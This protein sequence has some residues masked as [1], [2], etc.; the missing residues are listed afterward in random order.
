MQD[1]AGEESPANLRYDVF[2]GH[3]NDVTRPARVEARADGGKKPADE[4]GYIFYG[5]ITASPYLQFVQ[6]GALKGGAV[7]YAAPLMNRREC[8]KN[9]I[10]TGRVKAEEKGCLGV[11]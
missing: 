4:R 6:R 10:S 9:L 5:A 11:F 1:T 8:V 2:G 7:K 3:R